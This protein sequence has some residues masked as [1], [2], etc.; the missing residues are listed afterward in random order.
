MRRSANSTWERTESGWR[1]GRYSIALLRPGHW[2]LE[3]SDSTV[4]THSRASDAAAQANLTE[5]ARRRRRTLVV[6]LAAIGIAMLVLMVAQGGR[7]VPNV[8]YQSAQQYVSDLEAVY[9]S[10][11]SGAID[12]DD[13]T[14]AGALTGGAFETSIPLDLGAGPV[15]ARSY[16]AL[17]GVH[18]GD[19]YV[20]RWTPGGAVFTGVLAADLPCEPDPRLIQPE[21]FDRAASQSP[22]AE[23]FSWTEVLPPERFQA[24]WFVPLL[25][26][27]LY[28]ILQ[29]CISVALAFIRPQRRLIPPLAIGAGD[30]PV[31]RVATPT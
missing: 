8:E 17:T 30:R 2:A 25:L 22:N 28:V 23:A 27:M 24:R 20:I 18:A 5:G 9:W 26:A 13:V 31:P 10:V 11:E 29:S 19:C 12:I 15:P 1:Y 16:L 21:L 6:N 3:L 14:G 7:T 4:S